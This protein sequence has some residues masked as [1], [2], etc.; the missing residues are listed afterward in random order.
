MVIAVFQRA[1]TKSTSTNYATAD[2]H[3]LYAEKYLFLTWE[4]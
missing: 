3:R 2:D 4:P 1:D